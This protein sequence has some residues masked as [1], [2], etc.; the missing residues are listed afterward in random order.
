MLRMQRCENNA[1]TTMLSECV[2]ADLNTRL[3]TQHNQKRGGEVVRIVLFLQLLVACQHG[4]GCAKQVCDACIAPPCTKT[5]DVPDGDCALYLESTVTCAACRTA[6]PW[7]QTVVG[8]V[9]GPPCKETSECLEPA[10]RD[11]MKYVVRGRCALPLPL[12]GAFQ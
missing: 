10:S 6:W 4:T 12:L 9:V 3:S 1:A 11:K 8:L 5:S 7:S 2:L